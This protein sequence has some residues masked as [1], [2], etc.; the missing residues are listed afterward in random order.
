[1]ITE[2]VVPVGQRKAIISEIKIETI[3]FQRLAPE[4]PGLGWGRNINHKN[5]PETIKD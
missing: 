5:R 3:E 4:N 1:L 2:A